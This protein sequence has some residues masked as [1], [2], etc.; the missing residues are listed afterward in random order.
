MVR[1]DEVQA[2]KGVLDEALAVGEGGH[3]HGNRDESCADTLRHLFDVPGTLQAKFVWLFSL[4][5][6]ILFSLTIID[7]RN[8]RYENY[9]PATMGL[10][11]C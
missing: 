8:K 3:G 1:V 11:I 4:P 6:L 10:A 7:C 9:Y 2:S 5:L